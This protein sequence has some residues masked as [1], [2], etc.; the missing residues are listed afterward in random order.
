MQMRG[1]RRTSARSTERCT[2][3]VRRCGRTDRVVVFFSRARYAM[4]WTKPEFEVVDV[5]MEVTAYVARR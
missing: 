5:T 4:R 2:A 3:S 1:R